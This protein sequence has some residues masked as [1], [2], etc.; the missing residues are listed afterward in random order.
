LSTFEK[1]LNTLLIHT[2]QDI[3]KVEELILQKSDPYLSINEVHLIESVRNGKDRSRTVSE[4]ASDLQI[5]VPSVTVAVNKLVRKG[6]LIKKKNKEDGR[7]VLIKLTREGEKI[8]RLHW[9]IH[10][11]LVRVAAQDLTD[12]EKDALL[13][14]IKNLDHFFKKKI[15]KYGGINEFS[16]YR[17]RKS[18]SDNATDQ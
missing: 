15:A 6:Y 7:S 10:L 2:L 17:N 11:K 3:L 18:P 8:Y 16:N 13:I 1:E 14:G 9:Y 12:E 4:I 5:A